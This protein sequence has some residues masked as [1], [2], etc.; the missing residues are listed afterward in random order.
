M[1][2]YR[3]LFGVPDEIK[4][5]T[6]VSGKVRRR[7]LIYRLTSFDYQK[8]FGINGNVPGMTNGFREFTGGAHPPQGSPWVFGVPHQPLVGWWVSPKRPLRKEIRKSKRKKGEVGRK[9]RT[10]PTNPSWTR[11]GGG[12]LLPAFGRPPWGSLS[13]KARH[14]PSHLYIRRY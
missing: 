11:I 14:L 9:G 3:M 2:G 13:L 1:V 6:S 7:R 4:D 12:F 5:V 10:P 8:V